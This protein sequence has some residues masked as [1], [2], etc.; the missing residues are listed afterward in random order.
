MSAPNE[1]ASTGSAVLRQGGFGVLSI[2]WAFL[3]EMCFPRKKVPQSRC[4]P[5]CAVVAAAAREAHLPRLRP[6]GGTAGAPA[7][8]LLP[9]LV[10][11]V[12]N[13]LNHN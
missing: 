9:S 13:L 6:C 7:R 1:L 2:E 10:P 3:N 12:F 8:G 11:P 4:A 5:A